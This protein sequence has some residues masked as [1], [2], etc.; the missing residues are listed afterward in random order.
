MAL[1]K[2]SQHRHR[3][4]GGAIMKRRITKRVPAALSRRVLDKMLADLVTRLEAHALDLEAIHH[5]NKE[6]STDLVFEHLSRMAFRIALDHQE[7]SLRDIKTF[8][9]LIRDAAA[10]MAVRG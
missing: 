1:L 2:L 4:Q 9:R 5:A 3:D 8:A 7:R 6:N 10:R